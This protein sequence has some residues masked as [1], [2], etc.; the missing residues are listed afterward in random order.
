MSNLQVA[1]APSAEL[2]VAVSSAAPSII[3]PKK[4]EQHVQQVQCLAPYATPPSVRI[5]FLVRGAERVVEMPLP[6]PPNKFVEGIPLEPAQFMSTWQRVGADGGLQSQTVVSPE[7]G[8]VLETLDEKLTALGAPEPPILPRRL[9][10]GLIVLCRDE[11]GGRARPQAGEQG[12]RRQV[13]QRSRDAACVALACP[14]SRVRG[15]FSLPIAGAE[16]HLP[17]GKVQL[18]V[19]TSNAAVT[20]ALSGAAAYHCAAPM[21]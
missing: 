18:T 17:S 5:S 11:Q 16:S 14:P 20:G 3:P 21:G 4:Q 1:V 15:L 6:L 8:I 19:R 9:S 10:P 2:Q 7:G 12:F 13:R